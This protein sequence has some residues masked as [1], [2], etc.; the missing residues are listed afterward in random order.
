MDLPKYQQSHHY[1][2]KCYSPL[3]TILISIVLLVK[4]ANRAPNLP[5]YQELVISFLPFLSPKADQ[6]NINMA[7]NRQVNDEIEPND[8]SLSFYS[9]R[10]NK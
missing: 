9:V 6:H 4:R 2:F 5:L 7:D 1:E 10:K 8:A 3:V